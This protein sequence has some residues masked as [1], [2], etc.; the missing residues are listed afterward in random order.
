MTHDTKNCRLCLCKCE[1]PR[2]LLVETTFAS[3]VMEILPKVQISPENGFSNMICDFC[4][5]TVEQFY[6]FYEL[7]NTNQEAL[8]SVEIHEMKE[9]IFAVPIEAPVDV[10]IHEDLDERGWFDKVEAPLIEPPL[11]EIRK[12]AEKSKKKVAKDKKPK[13]VVEALENL[14]YFELIKLPPSYTCSFVCPLCPK[15]STERFGTKQE[16]QSHIMEKHK[17]RSSEAKLED[18]HVQ[19]DICNKPVKKFHQ[20]PDHKYFHYGIKPYKCDLCDFESHTRSTL[21][22]HMRQLHS[23]LAKHIVCFY[24]RIEFGSTF[25]RNEHVLKAH[26]DQLMTCD[27]CGEKLLGRYWAKLHFTKH[28]DEKLTIECERCPGGVRFHSEKVLQLHRKQ[29]LR[30]DKTRKRFACNLCERKFNSEAAFERHLRYHAKGH[31]VACH[32]CGKTVQTNSYL[33]MKSHARTHKKVEVQEFKCE[34]CD[35]VFQSRY[36]LTRHGNVVHNLNQVTCHLCGK[37][38][39]EQDLKR[40]LVYCNAGELKCRHC[41]MTFTKE[42]ARQLHNN[43]FH[44]GFKCRR[45]N[46]VFENR[47]QMDAHQRYDEYHV[48]TKSKK[49]IVK[50]EKRK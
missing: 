11:E 14:D 13:V 27:F 45:C 26:P 39:A 23:T 42:S 22:G 16:L 9:E 34:K 19:C 3:K 47:T 17:N 49:N 18:L 32:I 50:K 1:N 21:R 6:G 30:E 36:K 8:M 12:I 31:M 7:V 10:K 37:V 38:F 2:D 43:K 28:I 24:C 4:Y 41:P 15:R 20:N 46:I 5:N 44:T 48:S 33:Q 29:H 35:E 40:H 25:A